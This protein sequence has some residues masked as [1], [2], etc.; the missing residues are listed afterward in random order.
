VINVYQEV[1]DAEARIRPHIRLTYLEYSPY[2]SHQVGGQVYLKLECLQYT[3]SFKY[4]GALN[5]YLSLSEKQRQAPVITASSGNHGTA[6]A[7]ILH[8][9]GGQG[10]VFLPQNASSAKI[11]QLR[12]YEIDLELHGSDC[13]ESETLALQTA[14]QNNQ[15]FISPY[16]DPQ[17]IGGQG[18]IA[19]ELLDQMES[20]DAVLVPVGGGGLISGIA[21]YL[22]IIDNQ[23]RI[24]ACQ[25]E[26]SAVMHASIQAGQIVE[27]VSKPTVADGTAGGIDPQAI[28]FEICQQVVDDYI[29]VSETELKSAIHD[30]VIHHQLLIEGAAAL[31]VAALLKHKDQFK[32]QSIALI[33]SGKKITPALLKEILH[34]I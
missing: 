32:D 8:K 19:I 7:A 24:I 26:N 28:T 5:K 6:L 12:Q 27:T 2:L 16:N 1:L 9:Y 22:K 13:I 20:I 3:G 15:I 34:D 11:E 14:R 17:I 21:G 29:L 30:M 4:R 25:P 23:I 31:P 18:T 33:I 10:C